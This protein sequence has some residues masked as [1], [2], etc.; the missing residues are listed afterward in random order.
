M[1]GQYQIP[2][3]IDYNI[4]E[5]CRMCRIDMTPYMWY[6]TC[7]IMFDVLSYTISIVTSNTNIHDQQILSTC[8]K[9]PRCTDQK[10]AKNGFAVTTNSGTTASESFN[11][12]RISDYTCRGSSAWLECQF[13][14]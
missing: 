6:H 9:Q 2:H 4:Q 11:F 8:T 10:H 5:S 3:T 12:S 13:T 14:W 1:L 7:G